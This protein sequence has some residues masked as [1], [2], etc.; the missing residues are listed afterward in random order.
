MKPLEQQSNDRPRFGPRAAAAGLLLGLAILLVAVGC[1]PLRLLRPNERLLTKVVVESEG[2][3]PAQQERLLTLVQQKPNRTIP[4]PKLAVYQ[5]GHSFYDSARIERKI[6]DIRQRYADKVADAAN[7]SARRGKLLARRDKLLARR[8][9]A[10]EKGNAIMR[11]GEPPAQGDDDRPLSRSGSVS[12]CAT[13]LTT[14]RAPGP[15]SSAASRTPWS[16]S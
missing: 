5:L 16:C 11:L 14:P 9:T 3:L 1:S 10:L 4:I 6:K 13:P 8:R 15:G 7:D 2:L 12:R